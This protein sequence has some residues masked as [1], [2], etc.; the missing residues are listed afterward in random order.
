MTEIFGHLQANLELTN[1][2]SSWD[3]FDKDLLNLIT[4]TELTSRTSAQATYSVSTTSDEVV[5]QDTGVGAGANFTV[6]LPGSPYTGQRVVVKDTS[7]NA[8]NRNIVIQGNGNN[9]DGAGSQSIGSNYGTAHLVFDG[10]NW[11]LI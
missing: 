11:F 7:G 2:P 5:L 8:L 4:F 1:F 9:I 3:N 6:T 10:S